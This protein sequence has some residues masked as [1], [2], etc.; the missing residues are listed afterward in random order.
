MD[1]FVLMGWRRAFLS[2][3][4]SHR[5]LVV[6]QKGMDLVE[7]V[8]ALTKAFP[9]D[10][11]FR[12]I[13]QST[14]AAVSVP[15]NIAEGHSRSTRRDYA[16]FVAVAKGSLMELETYLMI[17]LRLG[18]LPPTQADPVLSSVEEISR[19]LTALRNRLIERPRTQ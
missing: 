8:Y 5:D 16:Y 18:Y 6:W 4:R 3:I 14:R 11:R 2:T 1:P 9:A 13:S 17:A 7:R 19:M 10:E 12:L 15:A